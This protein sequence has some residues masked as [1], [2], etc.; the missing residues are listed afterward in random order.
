MCSGN[1]RL[2]MLCL[3]LGADFGRSE[4]V[5]QNG[6]THPERVLFRA[7]DPTGKPSS[8]YSVTFHLPVLSVDNIMEA[9]NAWRLVAT[10]PDGSKFR[11]DELL[12]TLDSKTKSQEGA[13]ES[14]TRESQKLAASVR[15]KDRDN[16]LQ[17]LD[18]TRCIRVQAVP[19]SFVGSTER[20]LETV[21][22]S[23][24]RQALGHLPMYK[25]SLQF[26][27]LFSN[28]FKIR[29]RYVL[30]LD[31]DVILSS[32]RPLPAGQRSLM[33]WFVGQSIRTLQNAPGALLVQS[34]PCKKRNLCVDHCSP[35]L[36]VGLKYASAVGLKYASAIPSSA[37][38]LST[39]ALGE[40]LTQYAVNR[41]HEIHTE[42]FVADVD[43]FSEALR[44]SPMAP[45]KEYLGYLS[46]DIEHAF[47]V[48]FALHGGL[49]RFYHSITFGEEAHE[50]LT[51]WSPQRLFH[52]EFS[53]PLPANATPGARGIKKGIDELIH[54]WLPMQRRAKMPPPL[55]W[56]A[57]D[58]PVCHNSGTHLEQALSHTERE[59][60]KLRVAS[61]VR[62][63]TIEPA[64]NVTA[65]RLTNGKECCYLPEAVRNREF[66]L[67][68][69]SSSSFL[70]ELAPAPRPA[71]APAPALAP[72]TAPPERTRHAWSISRLLRT[73]FS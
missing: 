40:M 11:F 9:A 49:Y 16:V 67:G 61:Q 30:H 51:K 17:L 32:I 12:V 14:C 56:A 27:S 55:S 42:A 36:E 47:G 52:G 73:T 20:A 72:A 69:G 48:W 2:S 50:Q 44:S 35:N 22:G 46:I 7:C 29:T 3:L 23:F 62:Q 33:E 6:C 37:A 13:N 10:A 53:S 60:F 68:D 58:Y 25:T 63:G 15:T 39:D 8:N 34:S 1:L 59:A 21:Y 54:K 5:Q 26:Y 19:Y 18:L 57:N 24:K 45:S 71:P 28:A 38:R 64:N 66:L 41:D 43:R 4:H 31:A 70:P 65:I